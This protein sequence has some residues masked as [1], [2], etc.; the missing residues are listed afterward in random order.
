ML[1]AIFG[2]SCTGKSTLAGLLR[3]KLHAKV[4]AGKDYLRLAKNEDNAR[5]A[6]ATILEEAAYGDSAVIYVITEPKH[7]SL[8]PKN[9][10]RVRVTAPLSVIQSRF[11]GRMGGTLPTVIRDRLAAVHGV[12]DHADCDVAVDG[13]KPAE[14]VCEEI[15]GALQNR[16]NL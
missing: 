14:V 6:F 5:A 15:L 9:C 8:L 3:E 4:Y 10:L 16:I 12:F 2:E 7:L 1:I 11:A 13:S